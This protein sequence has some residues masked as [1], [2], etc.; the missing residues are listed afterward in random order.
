MQIS[1]LD[2]VQVIERPDLA[3]RAHAGHGYVLAQNVPDVLDQAKCVTA[4]DPAAGHGV[5][6]QDQMGRFI[7]EGGF[8]RLGRLYGRVVGI[9]GVADHQMR[10]RP[11]RHTLMTYDTTVGQDVNNVTQ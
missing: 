11:L 4:H 1:V 10:L 3:E 5:K 8:R 7:A 9:I 6:D 2:I